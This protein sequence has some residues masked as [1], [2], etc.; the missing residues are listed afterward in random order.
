M[1]AHAHGADNLLD[2][3]LVY[4]MQL[5]AMPCGSMHAPEHAFCLFNCN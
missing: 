2:L 4:A 1:A 5:L 3:V